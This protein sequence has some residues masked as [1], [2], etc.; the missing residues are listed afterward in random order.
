M[1]NSKNDVLYSESYRMPRSIN[2]RQIEVF[3][4]VI[5]LGTVSHA[6]EALNISQPAASK[7]LMQLESDNGLKLFDRRKGRLVPTPQSLHLFE[8]VER[9]FAGV[10][11][12]ESAIAFI[13]REDLGRLVVGLPPGLAG[14]FIQRTISGF[15]DSNPNVYCLIQSRRSRWLIEDVLTRQVDVSISPTPI[16]NPNFIVN[17]IAKLPLVCIMPIGHPLAEQSV[18]RPDHLNDMPFVAF[19]LESYTGQRVAKVLEQH[20][21]SPKI[22]ITADAVSSV[23]EFVAGGQGVS[24]VYPLF[25]AGMEDRVVARPF[26]AEASM[27]Q[28]LCYS[29]DA[30][31]ISLILEFAKHAEETARYF[32]EG[33]ARSRA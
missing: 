4:A 8:E 18:I 31:N 16:D 23:S 27:N 1:S 9:I 22:V 29:R 24:L 12:V 30:R 25:I 21:V 5:E 19:D 17:S 6:A 10:R 32:V 7:L 28:Y 33:V 11:Q 14:T 13:K 20:D 2:L 3:K 26:Q 15:L